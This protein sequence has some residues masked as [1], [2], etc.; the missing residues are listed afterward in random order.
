[1]TGVEILSSNEVAISYMFNFKICFI[2]ALAILFVGICAS[3]CTKN[4]G[5]KD[6]ILFYTVCGCISI[7][8]IAGSGERIPT[9]YATEYKVAISDEV[10][11]NEFVE[12]Y[13]I[14][15]QEGKI[16]TVRERE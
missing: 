12:K 6:K 15:D 7:G 16:Y 14:V 1:M 2:V 9:E 10:L 13:K 3:F 11:F 8:S 4:K 5:Y